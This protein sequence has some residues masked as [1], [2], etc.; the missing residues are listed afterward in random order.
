MVAKEVA[1]LRSSLVIAVAIA[2]MPSL[3]L[4]GPNANT[5]LVLHAVQTP[6]G[7][8]EIEDPCEPAPGAP[9]V[10]ITEPGLTH[11]VYILLRNYDNVSGFQCTAELE[12]DWTFLFSVFDCQWN[13]LDCYWPNFSC[14]FDCVTGGETA[15]MGRAILIPHTGCLAIVES[16]FPNGT[17]VV[18]C[19]GE[20]DAVTEPTAAGSASAPA[21][22][23]RANRW[24]LR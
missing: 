20:V 17:L 7:P 23:T 16:G 2:A 3:S 15:V 18:S 14:N 13:Q 1:M 5:T 8:C 6:Y 12:G 24:R 19:Q 9:I 4:A 10:E 11:A 22:S 21:E